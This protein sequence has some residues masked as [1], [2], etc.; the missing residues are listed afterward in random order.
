MSAMKILK[1][2]T[3]RKSAPRQTQQL[4]EEIF[5]EI[6]ARLP[7][8]SLLQF[9]SVCKAWRAIVDDPTF[10]RAHLLHSASKWE[11]CQ[12]FIISPHTLDR[13][14]PNQHWPTTF[15]NLFR[16]Y[17]WQLQHGTSPK[18]K[19]ATFLDAQVFPRQFN[20]LIYFTHCDGLLLAPTDTKLYLFNP[21]IRDAI[22]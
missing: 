11:C 5:F 7:V 10:I 20:T 9:R 12:N 15:S 8:K 1:M 14:I 21:A 6:L 22:T 13:V 4:M 17:Q 19:V 16:F 2:G 3:T 18:N